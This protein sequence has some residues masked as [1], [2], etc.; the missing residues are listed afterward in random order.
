MD[1]FGGSLKMDFYSNGIGRWPWII[2][3]QA[4]SFSPMWVPC[5]MHWMPGEL[6]PCSWQKS[7]PWRGIL[8]LLLTFLSQISPP[9]LS[10]LSCS[11][12]DLH[13][14]PRLQ[15]FQLPN[16]LLKFIVCA[17]DFFFLFWTHYLTVKNI[18]KNQLSLAHCFICL[19]FTIIFNKIGTVSI[20]SIHHTDLFLIDIWNHRWLASKMK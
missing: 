19:S 7:A 8:H 6:K 15:G 10:R 9:Q 16:L 14:S 18:L 4:V 17:N 12:P 1:H 5:S 2:R 11:T 3:Q 13:F 20:V